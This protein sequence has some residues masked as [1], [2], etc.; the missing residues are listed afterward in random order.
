MDTEQTSEILSTHAD[1]LNRGETGP[2]SVDEGRSAAQRLEVEPLLMTAERAKRALAPVS[3]SPAFRTHLR[4]GLRVAASH[5]Q[6]QNMLLGRSD[7]TWG[8]VIGAAALGSAA[9]LIAIAWRSRHLRH[10]VG[11]PQ[12]T[13]NAENLQVGQQG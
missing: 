4:D 9:G 5:K 2:E 11:A 10:G 13:A 1:R 7:P 12:I 8:W 6:M 3:M